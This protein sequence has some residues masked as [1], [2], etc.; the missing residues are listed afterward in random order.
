[1]VD[2]TAGAT[3]YQAR[4]GAFVFSVDFELSWGLVHRAE[5]YT[6]D[7]ARE[8]VNVGRMLALVDEHGIPGTWAVV[9]HLLLDRCE[10]ANGVKH[11]EI[12]RP[13][14]PWFSGDWFEEDPCRAALADDSWYAPDLVDRVLA[15]TTPQEIGSHSFSHVQVGDPGCSAEVFDSELRECQRLAAQRG[16]TLRSFV[17]PNDS[18]GHLDVLRRNGFITYRGRPSTTSSP[19]RLRRGLELLGPGSGLVGYP[20]LN[21]GL[22]NL[23]ASCWFKPA[24]RRVPF[25]LWLKSIAHR[26]RLAARHRGLFHL[27]VHPSDFADHPKAFRGLGELFHLAAQLRDAGELDIV[28]MGDLALQLRS[29][30]SHP[31][32]TGSTPR[33]LTVVTAARLHR[34]QL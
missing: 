16:V 14:Y 17:F 20:E 33:A 34:K 10:P 27:Y 21:G 15:A 26:L 1:M 24:N 6:Y 11:P 29:D 3:R 28:T 5:G 7:G 19:G 32:E 9:G 31:L 12:I 13:D 8:R 4:R 18:I 23:P 22:W 25:P 30:T 2:Q